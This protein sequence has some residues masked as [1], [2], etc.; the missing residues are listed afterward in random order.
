[1]TDADHRFAIIAALDR[2]AECLDRRDWAGLDEV[3]DPDVEAD[4]RLWQVTGI[5]ALRDRIRSML[6]GCGPTQHLLGNYRIEIA[7]DHATSRCYA[8]VMHFAADGSD[9]SFEVWMEYADSWRRT[10]DGWRSHARQ[11]TASMQR[12]D[13]SVLGPEREPA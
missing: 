7:G 11:A 2:Y 9:R 3:F 13:P 12:G 6:G 1:M 8:R 10:A 5:P 4:Y